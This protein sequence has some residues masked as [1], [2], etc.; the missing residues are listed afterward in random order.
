MS[1]LSILGEFWGFLN[2]RKKYWLM[3]IVIMLLLLGVLL[4]ATQGSALAPFIYT[5]F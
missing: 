2:Q 1:R 4:V 3:P 5:L